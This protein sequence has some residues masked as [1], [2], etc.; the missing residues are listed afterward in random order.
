MQRVEAA[1]TQS[2][3]EE[4]CDVERS[5]IHRNED[6]VVSIQ[7]VLTGRGTMRC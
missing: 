2:Q 3:E 4:P 6:V 1:K 7:Q 5:K